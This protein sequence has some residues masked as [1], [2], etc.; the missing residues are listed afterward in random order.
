MKCPYCLTEETKVI[1]KR[2]IE[3]TT[4]RRRECLKCKK[5]FTTHERVED[6][7]LAVI[8]RSGAREKYSRE[9][10]KNGLTKACE[11][12]G[13]TSEQIDE[14]VDKIETELRKLNTTEIPSSKIGDTVMKYLKRLDK[15]AYIRFASVYKEFADVDE[16][17]EELKKLLKK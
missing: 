12:R 1:D 3:M 4:R 13:V 9:K 10:I 14:T 11:K 5:R 17:Q 15:V 16:F 8:K 2:D 7:G 6:V